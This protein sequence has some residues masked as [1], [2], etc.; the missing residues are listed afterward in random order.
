MSLKRCP[1]QMKMTALEYELDKRANEAEPETTSAF[2]APASQ[3]P[4][5]FSMAHPLLSCSQGTM[6]TM[7]RMVSGLSQASPPALGPQP[8]I[9]ARV[10]NAWLHPEGW[11]RMM[12]P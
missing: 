1:L 4:A 3:P 7:S 2:S 6:M 9:L 8:G 11:C 12:V 5:S 10:A